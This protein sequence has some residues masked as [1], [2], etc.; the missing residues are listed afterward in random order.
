M[1]RASTSHASWG[2][3]GLEGPMPGCD[4]SRRGANATRVGAMR[5]WD[6]RAANGAQAWLSAARQVKEK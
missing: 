1:S 6:G 5:R 4:A 3:A 2:G